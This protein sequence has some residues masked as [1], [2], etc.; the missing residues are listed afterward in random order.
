M[1][2]ATIDVIIGTSRVQIQRTVFTELLDNSVVN[3]RSPYLKALERSEIHYSELV[4]LARKAEVPHPLFF[5]PPA[6][7]RAQV[8]AKLNK[9]LQGVTPETFTINTRTTVELR[10][11]ELIVK[12]L[13]RKQEFARKNDPTLK[14]NKIVGLLRK[15]R[16]TVRE[17]ANALVE[18]IGLDLAAIRRARKKETAR[19]LLIQRLEANQIFVS[20]S[21]RGYMPQLLDG[22]HFSGMT[23]RDTKVPFI[24]L[25]GGDHQDFQEPAGRQIFTLTLMTVLIARGVFAPVTYDANSTAPDPGREFDIVGEMLMPGHEMRELSIKDLDDVRATADSFKVTP[26]AVVVRAMRMQMLHQELG[27]AFLDD[28][29]T[30]FQA[31]PKPQP[32]PPKP[33][34]A[35][36]KYSGHALTTRMLRA[37]DEGRISEGEFC[38]VVCLNHIRPSGLSDLREALP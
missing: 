25:A 7:V 19:D 32:R 23:V 22:I 35:I 33:A 1:T 2:T 4:D 36:R 16:A 9:L 17:D 20:Q 31:R 10:N 6:Q 13:L 8:K 21:V 28:L 30:E 27:V 12:D 15:P 26:S 3:A 11:I 24:F 37:V 5:A 14:R 18:G 34:N 29:R 38:R